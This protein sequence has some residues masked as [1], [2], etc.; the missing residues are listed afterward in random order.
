MIEQL[1]VN[2]IKN[3]NYRL[4]WNSHFD[5]MEKKIAKLIWDYSADDEGQDGR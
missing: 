4:R 1:G 2:R 3:I 5:R